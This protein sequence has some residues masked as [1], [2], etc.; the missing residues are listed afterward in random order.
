[1]QD[2]TRARLFEEHATL[3]RRVDRLKDFIV[4]QKFDELPEIDRKDL[5]EQLGY[6]RA[7]LQVVSRRVSRQCGAA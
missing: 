2:E 6:M 1:M 5:K 3:E 4:T 7:Y